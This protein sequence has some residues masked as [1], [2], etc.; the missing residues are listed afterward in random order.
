[1]NRCFPTYQAASQ[2]RRGASMMCAPH[3]FEYKPHG[4][5]RRALKVF[6]MRCALFGRCTARHSAHRC[7]L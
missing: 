1:M 6:Q 7:M 2:L 3:P 5:G 4:G